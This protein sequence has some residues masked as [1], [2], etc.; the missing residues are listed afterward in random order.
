[1]YVCQLPMVVSA[2]H[3]LW[4]A[5]PLTYHLLLPL[6]SVSHQ[7]IAF[8]PGKWDLRLLGSDFSPLS[9]GFFGG[10]RP[11]VCLY[12]RWGSFG[13]SREGILK[14][15]TGEGERKGWTGSGPRFLIASCPC[16]WPAPEVVDEG[17]KK[18]IVLVMWNE[19]VG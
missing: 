14:H 12:C 11:L 5:R 6:C 7:G 13:L 17:A 18:I 19:L 15:I 1:M 10:S 2:W 16:Q 8:A 3:V 9:K 4:G